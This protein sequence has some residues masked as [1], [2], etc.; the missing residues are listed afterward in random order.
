MRE[1]EAARITEAVRQM[2]ID[3]NT[4]IGDDILHAFEA[5]KETEESP[6]ALNIL[7]Q[8][9]ESAGIAAREKMPYCQDTG[10]SCFIVELGQDVRVTG[11]LLDDAINAG[12]REGYRDGFLRK[13]IVSDPIERENTGDNTPAHIHVDV[14]PGD[15]LVIKFS[16]KGG[17]S[18]NMSQ[19]GMLKPADGLE[20]VKDFVV[21][22]ASE[23]GPNA[24]PPI[25][26]CVGIG[27]TFDGAALLAKRGVFREVGKPN[28]D[29]FYAQLEQELLG[30][31][32]QLGFGPQG[33]GGRT[34]ALAVHIEAA[35]CH[36]ASLPVAVN[37]QCHAHR[38][39]EVTL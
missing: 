32:N 15:R 5:A 28:A 26:V 7:D 36:I 14:V 27:G 21:K 10:F 4:D 1:I 34:S 20:G 3:A 19:L 2:C 23:A 33:L 35:P 39:R 22:V 9:E 38:H 12:V 8:I 31:V 17:G 13:S 11:G 16:A 29:P 24:C 30:R 37:I 6:L 25:I 18:E